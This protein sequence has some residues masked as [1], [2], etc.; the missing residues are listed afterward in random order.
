[1]TFIVRLLRKRAAVDGIDDRKKASLITIV[2]RIKATDNEIW[3]PVDVL[4]IVIESLD[5]MQATLF[6]I[7]NS[8]LFMQNIYLSCR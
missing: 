1:V 3:N 4:T 8:V 5:F 7:L 2:Q 6:G